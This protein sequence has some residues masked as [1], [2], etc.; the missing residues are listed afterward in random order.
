MILIDTSVYIEALTDAELEKSLKE[1]QNKS[2][3]I[4]SD[5]IEKE[6]KEA[7]DHLR[8][9]NRRAESERLNEIYNASISGTIRLTDRVLLIANMYSEKI[10][11][12]FGKDKAKDME[13]D[14]RIVACA[15][16][17]GLKFIGTFN[18]KTMANNEI[19]E[20]YNIINKEN[21][22]KTPEF[23]KSKE[24]LLALLSS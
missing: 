20:I 2:F 13:D 3:I 7:A 23:V 24:G 9:T 19:I 8:K 21:K 22:F 1:A 14:L 5:V 18:R 12:H 4:S 10:K 16:I 11:Q 6:I 17:A 15:S